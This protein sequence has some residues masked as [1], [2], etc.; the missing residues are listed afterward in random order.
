VQSQKTIDVHDLRCKYDTYHR[1]DRHLSQTLQFPVVAICIKHREVV[2]IA[3]VVHNAN[4]FILVPIR[5]EPVEFCENAIN[6]LTLLCIEHRS[7]GSSSECL[8][9][10]GDAVRVSSWLYEQC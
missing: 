8:V 7:G 9:L 6:L 1:S 3:G 10:F 4:V 2:S 5:R